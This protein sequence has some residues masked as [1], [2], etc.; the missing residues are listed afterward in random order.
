MRAHQIHALLFILAGP[1]QVTALREHTWSTF[2]TV[3]TP[4][5][6]KLLFFFGSGPWMSP[7]I[8]HTDPRDDLGT[9]I[10]VK[11]SAVVTIASNPVATSLTTA[12]SVE[13]SL[14]AVLPNATIPASAISV[15]PAPV[16]AGV[17]T[18]AITNHW[19]APLS[20]SYFQN[21]DSPSAIGAPEPAPLGTSTQVVL[22]TNWAGRIVIGKTTDPDASKIEG[23][24]TVW[25]DVD[26][27]YVDGF[28]VPIVCSNATAP[29][30]GC[31][32][33]LWD[34]SGPCNNTVGDHAVCLNP[35]Q[36]V[37]DGKNINWLFSTTSIP[38]SS[39]LSSSGGVAKP[40]PIGPADPWFLP[41]QGVAYTFPN[42]NVAND[43]NTG[44]P[45]VSCCI[46]TGDMGC[47]AP[48]MQGKGDDKAS[49]RAVSAPEKP[50]PVEEVYVHGHVKRHAA[51]TRLHGRALWRAKARS[52]G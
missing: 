9:T 14:G 7:I 43:G 10:T 40:L 6:G 44:T 3:Q 29:V 35:M 48:D 49:K 41:C 8:Q 33:N 32:I 25:N 37:P 39:L 13:S 22:P 47:S 1:W 15:S 21:S 26:V 46:G 52:Q 31:N 12:L 4:T 20:V 38:S 18:I 28:S 2:D 19:T 23:S 5:S 42:D 34:V 16:N 45:D 27:S 24:T 30:T 36:G 11:T 51:N 17:M 50:L